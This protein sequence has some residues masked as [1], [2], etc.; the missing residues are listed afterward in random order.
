[1]YPNTRPS[2]SY[3]EIN[4]EDEYEFD[5]PANFRKL[6]KVPNKASPVKQ[7]PRKKYPDK[8][9]KEEFEFNSHLIDKIYKYVYIITDHFISHPFV[10]LRKVI[11]L[12]RSTEANSYHLT[13]VSIVPIVFRIQ[14]KYGINGLMQGLT[15]VLI[16]KGKLL[17]NYLLTNLLILYNC[18][19]SI[20]LFFS[21][22]YNCCSRI[23]IIGSIKF[24]LC[25][26]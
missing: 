5:I 1:M 11:Q 24:E 23:K 6:R 20:I 12:D 4:M 2:T 13:P 8:F 7:S 18:L 16:T 21:K 25:K 15:S 14:A 19:K 3:T 10:R 17:T 22:R 9:A 26:L